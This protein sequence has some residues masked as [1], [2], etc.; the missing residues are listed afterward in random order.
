MEQG[1]VYGLACRIEDYRIVAIGPE[2]GG[3]VSTQ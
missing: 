3:F 1:E 2:P